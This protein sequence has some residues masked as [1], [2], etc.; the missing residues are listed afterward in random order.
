M[1][2][3][4]LLEAESSDAVLRAVTDAVHHHHRP[5]ADGPAGA[6]CG[7]YDLGRPSA[8]SAMKL[9]MSCGEIGAMR[10]SITSRR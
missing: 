7:Q 4:G 1:Q 2:R 10:V 5:K 6:V 3:P 8:F 9:R